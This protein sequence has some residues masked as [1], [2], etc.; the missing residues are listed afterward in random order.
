MLDVLPALQA[1]MDLNI[2]NSTTFCNNNHCK[3]Y[4]NNLPGTDISKCIG[5]QNEGESQNYEFEKKTRN[6]ILLRKTSVK[7]ICFLFVLKINLIILH[8]D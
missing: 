2:C 1:L 3:C 6:T 5:C 8:F 4:K 7:C